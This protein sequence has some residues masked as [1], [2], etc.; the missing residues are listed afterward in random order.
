MDTQQLTNTI[1]AMSLGNSASQK[2]IYEILQ[3]ILIMW[4]AS[5]LKNVLDWLCSKP[6][7]IYNEY[8]D[9]FIH[10]GAEFIYKTINLSENKICPSSSRVNYFESVPVGLWFYLYK[11]PKLCNQSTQFVL[12]GNITGDNSISTNIRVPYKKEVCLTEDIFIYLSWSYEE[13]QRIS[14]NIAITYFHNMFIAKLYCKRHDSSHLDNF[15]EKCERDYNT[16][17]KQFRQLYIVKWTPPT[18]SC[19]STSGSIHT[20]KSRKT[21]NNLFF[22]SKD[23]LRK[24][25]DYFN[26][27][28]EEYSRL[29]RPYHLGI[30][31]YG[32]PG[33]GKT[34]C[35][36]AIA[37]YLNKRILLVNLNGVKTIKL[38]LNIFHFYSDHI[39][40]FEEV[41]CSGQNF[42]LDR[43]LPSVKQPDVPRV[44]DDDI[45]PLTLGTFL[46]AL[47]GMIETDGRICIFTTNYPD[48]LDKALIR[49]GRIDLVLEMKKM[50]SI[51]VYDMYK[52]WFNDVIPKNI[53]DKMSDYRFSQ[54][55]IGKLFSEHHDHPK[56]ILK[57]LY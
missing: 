8:K 31:L 49:P 53:F 50:R 24:Q 37:D 2:S 20:S 25:L 45:E 14:N 28:K 48:R 32:Q 11:H 29:G 12:S 47:D 38:L 40:V 15:L 13:T 10:P 42:L 55:E 46:E 44:N 9:Y 34:S 22:E 35:I 43:S 52:L 41:D 36:K 54:A 26:N 19:P 4:V 51:D 17:L 3:T 30:L 27:N 18:R 7:S 57:K 21:F 5:Y 23:R 6:K 39:I 33:T 56:Q 16:H 1:M